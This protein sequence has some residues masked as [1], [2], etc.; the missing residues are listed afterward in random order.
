MI[1]SIYQQKID[2]KY[3]L[4]HWISQYSKPPKSQISDSNVKVFNKLVQ[5]FIPDFKICG[6]N[7]FVHHNTSGVLESLFFPWGCLEKNAITKIAD[8]IVIWNAVV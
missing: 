2:I 3:L 6:Y 4:Y 5:L 1:L 8:T 7:S